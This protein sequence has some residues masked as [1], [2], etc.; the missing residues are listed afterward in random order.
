[1]PRWA[2]P[3][4]GAMVWSE[5][6]PQSSQSCCSPPSEAARP[7]VP[8]WHHC[9]L[10][11]AQGSCKRSRKD[12]LEQRHGP[13]LRQKGPE[14]QTS[15]GVGAKPKPDC[16]EGCSVP[17]AWKGI[18][19]HG[20]SELRAARRGGG[21]AWR[22]SSSQGSG[23]LPAF[24]ISLPSTAFMGLLETLLAAG[25]ERRD[26]CLSPHH[27]PGWH[28]SQ[29]GQRVPPVAGTWEGSPATGHHCPQEGTRGQGSCLALPTHLASGQ[30]EVLKHEGDQD[31]PTLNCAHGTLQNRRERL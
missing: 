12:E 15:R 23:H 17:W 28:G 8:L 22:E 1:M 6:L 26:E 24:I 30:Q 2:L 18:E 13:G 10:G 7:R 14:P 11:P 16:N 5:P 20:G 9:C 19:R 27:R 31:S 21:A 4:A 3:H 29:G 25:D